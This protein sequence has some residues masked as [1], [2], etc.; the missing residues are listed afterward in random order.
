MYHATQCIRRVNRSFDI[1]AILLCSSRTDFP[2]L[3]W[4]RPGELICAC[5]I[6][7]EQEPEIRGTKW[8]YEVVGQPRI[9]E[10]WGRMAAR[11]EGIDFLTLLPA[12][13][14]ATAV[15]QPITFVRKLA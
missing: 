12:I 9:G 2:R 6:I 15:D 4:F 13:N 14:H 10:E 11:S 3:Q 7:L 8:A 5:M 1:G